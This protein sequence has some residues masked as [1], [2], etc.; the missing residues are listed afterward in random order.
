MLKGISVSIPAGAVTGLLGP[1][2]CGKSTLMRS[3]VGVQTLQSGRVTVLGT[4]AGSPAL[5]RAVGYVTQSPSV[6]GDLTVAENLKF[7]ASV[8]DCPSRQR[9]TRKRVSRQP[10]AVRLRLDAPE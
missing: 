3:V 5:R 4:A 6:Y 9:S 10:K 1:S 8:L 7:F 2:G